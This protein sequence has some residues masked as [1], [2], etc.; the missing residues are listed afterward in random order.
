M[1]KVTAQIAWADNTA[2]LARNIAKGLDTIELNTRRVNKLVA[3]FGSGAIRQAHE[4]ATAV[5]K[6]GGA[7]ALTEAQ[8]KRVNDI[9]TKALEKYQLLGEKAPQALKDL[10]DATKKVEQPTSS[11]SNW[12]TSLG[13]EIGTVAAG[14]ISAQA[15]IGTVRGGFDLILDTVKD[16]VKAY[17]DAE[18]AQ[19]K[20]TAALRQHGISTPEVIADYNN[21]A[22]SFQQ[23]TV[24]S[25][26][27]ITKMEAL[28]TQVGGVMPSKMKDALKA[29]T[30]LAAGLGIDLESATTLVAKAAAGHT[31]TLG[32]YGITVSDAALKTQG[33]D[34]VLE[35]VNRQFG[36]QAASQIET[37]AGKVEQLKNSWNNVEEAI[38]KFIVTDPIVA[39]ALS[40]IIEKAAALDQQATQ[41]SH[42]VADLV[43]E[44]TQSG[45]LSAEVAG[46][47]N[48]IDTLN[49]LEAQIKKTLAAGS[50]DM[51]KAHGPVP[52]APSFTGD[53]GSFTGA[54]VAGLNL[55][56]TQRMALLTQDLSEK[57]GQLTT[58]ERA[59]ALASFAHGK[60]VEDTVKALELYWPG[61]EKAKGA[62]E[63]LH[64]AYDDGIEKQ[65]KY[66]E[67]ADAIATVEQGQFEILGK[68]DAA[69]V[70]RIQTLAKSGVDQGKLATFFHLTDVEIKAVIESGT[71][72]EKVMGLNNQTTLATGDALEKL[73]HKANDADSALIAMAG[74]LDKV[75]A[76]SPSWCVVE[77]SRG[78]GAEKVVSGY[79]GETL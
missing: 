51:F 23:T 30:D 32:R 64:K 69:T 73:G 65:K 22:T 20:L 75:A 28:L 39:R 54:L 55:S 5:D 45:E 29:S 2:D 21:L 77:F 17:A 1:S 24:F 38:G 49:K 72:L 43:F 46:L 42:G 48:Y 18:A 41:S 53:V 63:K 50:P 36:G 33:F 12:M 67:A 47:E 52:V 71:I 31:E 58:T 60:S 25:D 56:D 11:L 79:T 40:G 13:K 62:L 66:K 8:Q 10:A 44:L 27:L 35:A 7:A 34:A 19:T 15:V 76:K 57:T 26:D 74:T 9:V 70:T 59:A 37:Y 4:F 68:L 3:D 14:F 61:I 6:V 78:P 16:S